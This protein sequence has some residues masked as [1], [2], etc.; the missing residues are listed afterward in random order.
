MRIHAK[1]NNILQLELIKQD[2]AG[3]KSILLMLR[4][5]KRGDNKEGNK[6]TCIWG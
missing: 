4:L 3:D 6:Q 5:Q 1:E 2:E